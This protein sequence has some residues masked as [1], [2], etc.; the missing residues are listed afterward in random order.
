MSEM[1]IEYCISLLCVYAITSLGAYSNSEFW[2]DLA[3]SGRYLA[4]VAAVIILIY[5]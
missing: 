1:L 3:K 5:G 4:A 2:Q